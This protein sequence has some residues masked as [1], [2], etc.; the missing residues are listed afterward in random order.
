V[1]EENDILELEQG[2][3][4]AG[5]VLEDV[6]ARAGDPAESERAGQGGLVHHRPAGGVDE[7]GGSLHAPQFPGTDQVAGF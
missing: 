1:G 4:N 2:R 7:E 5:L 3:M 6:Q